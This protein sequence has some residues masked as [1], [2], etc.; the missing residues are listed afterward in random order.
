MEQR[1]LTIGEREHIRISQMINDHEKWSMNAF[2]GFV[3]FW[4]L[5]VVAVALAIWHYWP[6]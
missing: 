2:W 4:T 6:F 3:I 1:R 5:W